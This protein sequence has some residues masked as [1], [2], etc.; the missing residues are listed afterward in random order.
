MLNNDFHVL[1]QKYQRY[2]RAQRNRLMMRIGAVAAVVAL[3]WLG[4]RYKEVLIPAPT[5]LH[6]VQQIP[7]PAPAPAPAAHAVA[8]PNPPAPKRI[9]VKTPKERRMPNRVYP[10]KARHLNKSDAHALKFKITRKENLF[11]LIKKQKQEHS[12]D[13]A[14]ALANYFFEQKEYKEAIKWAIKAS[15]QDPKNPTPWILYAKCKAATGKK[16]IAKKA[17]RTYLKRQRSK[18]VRNLLESL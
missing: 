4:Y 15:K 3:G 8:K 14:I 1:E 7:Q 16:E 9:A 2:R 11:E 12:Y 10:R 18:E 6:Q 13:S 17:L 5:A